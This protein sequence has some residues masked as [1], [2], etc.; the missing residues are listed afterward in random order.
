MNART[1]VGRLLALLTARSPCFLVST[2]IF[3]PFFGHWKELDGVSACQLAECKVTETTETAQGD[4]SEPTIIRWA[5]LLTTATAATTAFSLPRT[6]AYHRQILSW[7][8]SWTRNGPWHTWHTS[9]VGS[10][11]FTRRSASCM[12]ACVHTHIGNIMVTRYLGQLLVLSAQ[13]SFG[14]IQPVLAKCRTSVQ[15]RW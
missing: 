6:A 5:G 9:V 8:V 14:S 12:H 10:S 2:M 11:V 13:P 15:R 4:Q 1:S 3:P 7:A